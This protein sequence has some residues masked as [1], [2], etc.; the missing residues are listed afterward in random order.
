MINR[1][2]KILRNTTLIVLLLT[3]LLASSKVKGQASFFN[4]NY[5]GPDTLAVGAACN[6][7]LQGNIPNPVVTSTIGATITASM[8][9]QATSGFPFNQ[10]FIAGES[11]HVFW[12]V[13][14]NMGN[15]HI[16]DFWIVFADLT[17]PTFD[18][19]GIPNT[20]F[21]ASIVQVPPPP[22]IPTVD[23]CNAFTTQFVESTRPDTCLAGSFT[24][25]WTAT[26]LAGNQTTFTQ[27]INIAADVT[28][29][30]ITFPPQNGSAPCELLSTAYPAWRTAQIAAFSVQDPSGIKSVTNN[31]PVN[32]PPGC[33]VPITVVFRATDNCNLMISTTA[34]FTTSDTEAP[35]VVTAPKDTV[36]YCSAGGNHLAKLNEWIHTH[37]YMSVMDS[38]SGPITFTMKI[39]GNVVDSVAVVNAF[40][41]SFGMLCG[42]QTIGSQT[43]QKVSAL[44]NVEF[45]VADACG[46]QISAG[47]ATFAAADTLPPVITGSGISEQCGGGNDQSA[48]ESWINSKGNG[49]ITDDC[50]TA[51]WVNFTYTTS[52]GQ[53]GSGIFGSGPYP[54]VAANNCTWSADVTFHA[55]DECGNTSSNTLRFQIIDTQPP[56]FS[57]LSPNITVHCPNPL[58]TVPAA[59]ITDNCDASVAVTFTRVYQDS[60]CDGSYTVVTTW[61]ATDDC[62]NSSTALQNIFVRDTT[63]PVFSLVPVGIVA[64][65]DTFALPPV[66]V[67]GVNI[68]AV[69]ACS[70]VVSITTSTVS[71]Q[72]PNPA[73]CTHYAYNILRTFTATDECGNTK[74]AI[75]LITVIDN[76]PP[77]PGGVLDTTAL[78]SSLQ[79]FPAPIPIATDACSGITAAP[80][81]LSTDS[82][83][84]SCTGNYTL[85]LHWSAQD[86]CGNQT[87]FLQVVHVIDTVAPTLSNIPV[88]TTVE[89][90][91]IPDPP[92]TTSFN[93]TDLC[94]SGVAIVLTETEIREPNIDSCAHWTD[95]VLKREWTAMDECGNARTYTQLIQIEDTTP[96]VIL[97]P[98]ELVVGNDPDNCG[99]TL[100]IPPPLSIIDDCSS[101]MSNAVLSD[102]MLI[103]PVPNPPATNNLLVDSL[104]FQFIPPN[105]PP[106]APATSPVNLN[107]HIDIGDID[108]T[109]EYFL[110]YGENGV[111]LGKTG[112]GLLQCTTPSD[113]NLIITAAQFN[114]W[115]SDGVLQITLAPYFAG[116]QVGLYVNPSCFNADV[117]M[118]LTYAYAHP[119][120]PVDLSYSVDGAPAIPY[121]PTGP[122][123]LDEGQHIVVYTA[124][125]CAGNSSTASATIT[126]N[127]VQPPVIT[128]PAQITTFVSAGACVDT[129]SLPFPNIF[130][131]CSM[132][133]SLKRSSAFQPITFMTDPDAG[134]IPNNV[135]MNIT[136]LIPNAVGD[137]ILRVRFKGEFVNSKEFFGIF[138]G[139]NY[140]TQTDTDPMRIRCVDTILTNF[141]VTAAQINNWA[142]N[143]SSIFTAIPNTN[144]GFPP[145]FDFINPCSLPLLPDQTDG[146]SR[147]QATLEYSYAVVNFTITN[148]A[149]VLVASGGIQGNNTTVILPPGNYTVKYTSTDHAGL[150]AMTTFPLVIKDGIAPTALCKPSLIIPVNPSGVNDY[151]LQPSEINN[152]SFDNC[153]GTNLSYSLSQTTFTCNQAGNNYNV[154]LTVTDTS[155]NS[156]TCTTVVG[157]QNQLPVPTFDA[158][159][160]GD[161]LFLYANPPQP[162]LFT[163]QWSGPAGFT[164]TDQNPIRTN[165][166]SNFQ[167][168]YSVTITGVGCAASGGV[169]V[170]FNSLVIPTITVSGG[171]GINFC[172]GQ[173]VVLNTPSAGAN[174]MYQWYQNTM[175]APTL[176]ATTPLPTYT[177]SNLL[178]GQYQFFVKVKIGD[179]V[180]PNSLVITVN[181][182][183][184][185]VASVIDDHIVVCEGEMITLGTTV[186]G[187]GILY[188]WQGPGFNSTDQYPIVSNSASQANVGIYTLCTANQTSGCISNPCAS[189]MVDVQ[190]TPAKPQIVGNVNICVGDDV[191]LLAS[192]SG[193]VTLYHW[194]KVNV[195]SFDTVLN[196]ITLPDL[197]LSDCGQWR[198]RARHGICTSPWSDPV[199]VCPTP[200]PDISATSN[201]PI[202]KDS[203]L[204]FTATASLPNLSWCWTLPNGMNVYEQNPTVTPGQA[205]TYKVVAKN[206]VAQCADMD[207]VQV[208]ISTP[209]SIESILVDAPE[210][211]DGSA[212]C[213][214]PLIESGFS[215][216]ISYFWTRE[217]T[218]ISTDS[219]LCFPNVT[220][221][222]NGPYTLIVKDSLGCPSGSGTVTLNV[223]AKVLTPAISIAPNPVCEGSDVIISIMNSQDYDANSSFKWV[224]GTDTT[225]TDDPQLQ[226]SG[227][228]L[229]QAGDYFVFVSEGNCRS[230]NSNVVKLIVNPIPPTPAITTNQP[231]C[232]GE[233]LSLNTLFTSGATYV[234]SGPQGFNSG[235]FNPVRNNALITHQGTYF[236][237]MIVNG[238]HSDTASAFV[239]IMQPPTNPLIEQ[240]M[241]MPVCIEQFPVEGSLNVSM[242]TQTPGALYTWINPATGDTLQ[243]P[244][245][246]HVLNFANLAPNQFTPGI[247]QF[248][249][250]A[251]KQDNPNGQGC[252]SAFSNIVSVSFDTIPDNS[253]QVAENHPACASAMIPLTA[254]PP[255]GNI[256]GQWK[257]LSNMPVSIV[258]GD[259]PNAQFAGV[260]GTTYLFTYTLSS[261]GCENFSSDTVQ[262]NVVAPESSHAGDDQ[263]HCAGE[264]V[265]LNATQGQYSTGSWS[266]MGQIGVQIADP[267]EPQS[268]VTG[269][270]PGNRYVFV[271]TL[272]DI[273][274]GAKSDTVYV[275]VYSGKPN[276]SGPDFVCTG[277]NEA[278]LTVV[279]NLQSWEK[280]LWSS[281]LGNLIFSPSNLTSTTVSN[282]TTGFNTIIWTSN[283]AKCGSDSR[284]TF[285][286]RYEIY[287]QAI[288]DVVPVVFGTETPFNVLLNDILPTDPPNVS[289]IIPPI[290]G[291]ISPGPT[292]GSF[293]YRPASGFTGTDVMTYR[294]C[295][296][297]CE[298][299]CSSATVS[300]VVGAPGTCKPPTIITPNGDAQ[301]E[302]YILG[303][304]CFITGEGL[305]S[306]IKVT[307]YNQ[308]GDYVYHSDQYPKPSEPGH[309]DGTSPSGEP[310][311]AGT[312]FYLIQIGT[313]KPISGFVLLQR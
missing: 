211:A 151:T 135:D 139:A 226:L 193:P 83:P 55:T 23:N 178:P 9:D 185:P 113:T 10:T 203:L 159:C 220:P 73:L 261:G 206:G 78:C 20:L 309:W 304:E 19:T 11:A 115:A 133:G 202:C 184:R 109:T 172:T 47:D 3:G 251:W 177:L 29:P 280:G 192:L 293:F 110:V 8:F 306:P 205:G 131:N 42:P 60:L 104:F 6:L 80:T 99:A 179:C 120:V 54:S 225:T 296:I 122:T 221:A 27:T 227:I 191:N 102:T 264:E 285:Y 81:Y 157:V 274:C 212:A 189:V 62:G 246:S 94:G 196:A 39:N 266:Q 44:V 49:S 239:D 249:V 146:T 105:I 114:D 165:T 231:V 58:P 103:T 298:N 5:N 21:F 52:S 129:V 286:T 149:N 93:G 270:N 56:V 201:A 183:A 137:G 117:K 71:F 271:W 64:R 281:P 121:P 111:L 154:V 125:D 301:N 143:G 233:T 95:W 141:D 197:T 232:I 91:N 17:G 140:L 247:H 40:N 308:W 156:S 164:S 303:D 300:F 215:G 176:I 33:T 18:L 96:P 267:L 16:F 14:D 283:D 34:V 59:T 228:R 46:N 118:K 45:L 65:C 216:D 108:G 147:I 32:F 238:C 51:S 84:G 170:N 72:N 243:G 126:V 214:S 35:V 219:L 258:N 272:N 142:T 209:P 79:P 53:N 307:I 134:I 66:P 85:Q 41:G 119:E 305:E 268:P 174:V 4:F 63:K 128:P 245:A 289:V 208:W 74:T 75:Q 127:D 252:N 194:E 291:T 180:S 198:V 38:C 276:I 279:P 112:K 123:F 288:P 82:I 148:S 61:R 87:N 199:T 175:P 253:A 150:M 101:T 76:L 287:P 255:S 213:F 136:G 145:V 217:G 235:L 234:W 295:N 124:V 28:P 186:T 277:E 77:V 299:A 167:G 86:V 24:R 256:T 181:M 57:G 313:Q 98:D 207:S 310:L 158:V 273:G 171:N 161:T 97:T 67:Q 26:D 250:S 50:S 168:L 166:Q 262:I 22:S 242:S 278:N 182:N 163:Y 144:P 312:Y 294:I 263:F 30:T 229:N 13:A 106:A 230:D 162:G 37:A 187:S 107:I 218:L 259:T 224:F 260:A 265:S 269:L 90:N 43:I 257:H 138:Q 173:N 169:T 31:A 89:C 36:A 195:L 92:N 116:G 237:Y 152:G 200:Y 68:N 236:V 70:P 69:D 223:Q 100:I 284:D 48:L 204:K 292:T 240:T 12:F 132:S 88:N 282:L 153:S 7:A 188:N 222:Q 244:G 160:E 15:S 297:Q 241:P 210:C 155:G 290:S 311:P 1:L 25:T 254:T 130:E 248:Q 2:R 190:Y 302:T 275:H